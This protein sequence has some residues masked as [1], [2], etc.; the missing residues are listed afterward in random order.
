MQGGVVLPLSPVQLFGTPWTAACQA[1]LSF[2]ICLGLLNSC[3]L[4]QWCYLTWSTV[5]GNG[6]S[7]QYSCLQ[8]PMNR[9]KGQKCKVSGKQTDRRRQAEVFWGVLRI[10][11]LGEGRRWELRE[12]L[13]RDAVEGTRAG[14]TGTPLTHPGTAAPREGAWLWEGAPTGENWG[15]RAQ[16]V[17]Q[18]LLPSTR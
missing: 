11:A 9:T 14:W 15:D 6:K 17:E 12:K 4:S 8:N 10:T 2:S 18:S 5:E 1:S 3:L 7:L 16:P 13:G